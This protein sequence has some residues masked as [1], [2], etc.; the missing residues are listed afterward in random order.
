MRRLLAAPILAVALIAGSAGAAS[1]A[2]PIGTPPPSDER[3]KVS[4]LLYQAAAV[5]DPDSLEGCNFFE[6]PNYHENRKQAGIYTDK[7]LF[8]SLFG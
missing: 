8:S 3:C 6:D 5:L 1:A 2:S 7:G 4:P